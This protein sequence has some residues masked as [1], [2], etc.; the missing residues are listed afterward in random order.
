M[1]KKKGQKRM[2]ITEADYMLAQRRAARL[3]EIAEHGKP[4]SF[5]KALH[6]SKKVYDRK[7]L[8][9]QVPED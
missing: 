7:R 4:I 1:K 9:K 5:R 6:K 3:E 2:R 8:K